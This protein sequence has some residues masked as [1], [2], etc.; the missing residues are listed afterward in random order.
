MCRLDKISSS[1][2]NIIKEANHTKSNDGIRCPGYISHAN[3]FDY[4]RHTELGLVDNKKA[5]Y[6]FTYAISFLLNV[7][8]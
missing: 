1:R 3:T 6:L 4:S 5:D 8:F 2:E 7:D